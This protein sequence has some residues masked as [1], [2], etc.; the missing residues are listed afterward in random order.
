M[1][2]LTVTCFITLDSVV[3]DPQLWSGAFQ[4][5]DTGELNGEVLK[6]ADAMVLGRV[7]YEGFAAAWPSR[8][9]DLFSD[10]FNSMPKY[11]VTTTLERADW[12]NTTILSDDPFGRIRELKGERNL[13]VW[14]SPQLVQGLLDEELVDELVLLYSP[15]VRGEGKRLFPDGGAPRTLKVTDSTALS[16]GMLAVRLAAA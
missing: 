4:S 11:V 9:G 3:E 16:G 15:I 10:K 5:E 14:G 12:N 13:L 2:K 7:T 8:S 1:G 6:E